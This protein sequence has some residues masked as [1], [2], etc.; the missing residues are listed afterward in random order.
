MFVA[1]ALLLV[2]AGALAILS[3]SRGT[4]QIERGSQAS[5][6]FTDLRDALAQFV[7]ANGRLPCPANP[8]ADTGDAVP[9]AAIVAC[10]FPA[11]TV[12]WKTLGVRREDAIDPWG[13]KFAYRVYTGLAG[14]LTQAGGASM[15]NCDTV[16]PLPAGATPVV[17]GA[18]GLCRA[19]QDTREA[20]FLTGKGLAINHFG[21]AVADAGYV[22]VSHGPTGLGAFT[23]EGQQKAM[24]ASADELANLSAAGPFVAKAVSAAGVSP[25]AA[26]HFDDLLAYAAV[27]DL[28]KRAGMGARDWPEPGGGFSSVLLNTAT[29]QAALGQAAPPAAGD[30]GTA[31]INFQ[32]AQVT[33]FDSGGSQNIALV[34]AAGAE[35]IGVGGGTL[36]SSGGEGFRIAFGQKSGKLAF[37]L[38]DFGTGVVVIFGFPF[39]YF[40]RVD[41]TFFDGVT[42]L[43]TVSKFGCNTDGGLASFSIDS[44]A[45]F[46]AEFDSIEMRPNVT[47]PAFY[48]SA[49]VLSEFK[50]CPAAALACETSL[51]LV[52]PPNTC[53]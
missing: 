41:I 22:L 39:S 30:L 45:A 2:A 5:Q 7:A 19:A 37:T 32:N 48:D 50:N 36:S 34:A 35:G 10:T 17:A 14:S 3:L 46:A 1:I 52:A 29:L 12:P 28:V 8:A 26:S 40:E 43:G 31:S 9:D 23:T 47:F 13:G 38:N 44:V 49:F 18:G 27:E 24:P 6:R 53:P 4:A 15:V 21:I 11:G 33:G 20:Q 42:S 16:E 25:E 51:S